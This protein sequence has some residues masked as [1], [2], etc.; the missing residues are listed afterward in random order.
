MVVKLLRVVYLLWILNKFRYNYER[1]VGEG[2]YLREIVNYFEFHKEITSKIG[3]VKSLMKH[4]NFDM[5]S[6]FNII[7]L[8]YVIN[9]QERSWEA[10]I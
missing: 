8:V 4:Y 9:F 2:F 3:L 6:P 7:P 5:T 1:M 10:D